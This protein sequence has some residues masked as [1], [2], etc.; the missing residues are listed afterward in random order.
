[1]DVCSGWGGVFYVFLLHNQYAEFLAEI[2]Y[3][4]GPK[5]RIL[6]SL[7]IRGNTIDWGKANVN[8]VAE[9]P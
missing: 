1:M 6:L 8:I 7:W 5:V 4:Y 9:D 2:L 3:K